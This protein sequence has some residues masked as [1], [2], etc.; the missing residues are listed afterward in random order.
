MESPNHSVKHNP[1]SDEDQRFNDF[2]TLSYNIINSS[3]LG[4]SLNNYL[5]EILKILIEY[6]G[7][8]AIE[9]WVKV[10]NKYVNCKFSHKSRNSFQYLA[11]DSSD[12]TTKVKIPSL[13]ENSFI[14]HLLIDT[15]TGKYDPSSNFFTKNGSFW[16]SNIKEYLASLPKELQLTSPTDNFYKECKSLVM[17][18]ITCE[19][20]NIGV[21]LM[22]KSD[23]YSYIEYEIKFYENI[24]HSISLGLINQQSRAALR[25]RIKE[26]TCLYEI[27]K[28]DKQQ[29]LTFSEKLQNIVEI[30]PPAWQYP[31]ITSCRILLDDLI[32]TTPVFQKSSQR[33]TSNII[34]DG[35]KRGSIEIMYSEKRP[36]LDEG[37]FLIEERNLIDTIARQISNIVERRDEKENRSKLEEQLQHADRLATLGQLTAGI[38][39]ELNEPLN[40]ILGFA[41]LTIKCKDLPDQVKQDIQKIEKASLYS[42]EIIKKLMLFSRQ[43]QPQTTQLNLNKI[44]QDGLYLLKSRCERTGIEIKYSLASNLPILMGDETQINQVLINLV[45]NSIQAMPDGGELE[46]KTS[47]K[48]KYISLMVI[49][50]GIGISNKMIDKIFLPFFTTKDVNEGTGLG[51]SVVHGI[52]ALHKGSLRV[53]SRVN[54]GTRFEIMLPVD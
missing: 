18:P 41:Q 24:I 4:L 42:R 54:Q 8:D 20:K 48:D 52:V 36:Q 16:T 2:R 5:N 44:I 22:M 32:F 45:V 19:N 30:L 46:I 39:H 11:V 31:K 34:V 21:L 9:I 29:D 51:L 38:A 26:I 28:V 15:I 37:P 17:I 23:L 40:S 53:E 47:L 49:D 7:Y 13:N 3:N 6:S 12:S 1:A 50:T 27:S 33:Q 25:E 14:N 35:I 10:N 43:I